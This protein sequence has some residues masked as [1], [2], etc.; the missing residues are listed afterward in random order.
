MMDLKHQN[1]NTFIGACTEA[2][3][4]VVVWEYCTK[5]SLQDVIY[6]EN[7][8]LDDMFKFCLATD[9]LKVSFI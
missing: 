8:K 3:N 7:M 1:L 5:G 4:I 6:G 9:I 2:P